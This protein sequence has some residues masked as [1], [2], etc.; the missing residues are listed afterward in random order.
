M[1][2]AGVHMAAASWSCLDI[3]PVR[4]R[5][6]GSLSQTNLALLRRRHSLSSV[7]IDRGLCIEAAH[8]IL[9]GVARVWFFSKSQSNQE[10]SRTWR[11]NDL[12][13]R[14]PIVAGKSPI[15]V[16]L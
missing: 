14:P 12:R 6:A 15:L 9:T 1:D 16:A 8:S 2:H 3:F 7:G 13:A 10:R 4:L 11:S 5:M